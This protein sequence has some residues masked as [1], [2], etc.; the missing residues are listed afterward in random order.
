MAITLFSGM[1]AETGDRYGNGGGMLGAYKRKVLNLEDTEA[2]A[3][4]FVIERWNLAGEGGV[5]CMR[6]NA[7]EGEWRC[8]I[9]R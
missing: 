9:W 1:G 7:G 2:A 5:G 4:E 3:I 6:Y 8:L